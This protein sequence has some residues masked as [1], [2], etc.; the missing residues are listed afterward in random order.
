VTLQYSGHSTGTFQSC[1]EAQSAST[2]RDENKANAW[3]A[4]IRL[5][6]LSISKSRTKILNVEISRVSIFESSG[7]VVWIIF[8][9]RVDT[10][11]A[12]STALG[13]FTLN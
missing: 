5:I 11:A 1:D 9:A 3:G 8:C 2:F 12:P 10:K 4:S 13:T 7:P 6:Q